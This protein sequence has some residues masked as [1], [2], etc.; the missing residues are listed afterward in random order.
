MASI[1]LYN[2]NEVGSDSTFT[3][4]TADE[5][6]A[7]FLY[8][9]DL[10]TKLSSSGSANGV[11]E[12]FQIVFP[13]SKTI[14]TV[15][16]FGHNIED[17][18]IK[19]LDGSLVEQDF[20]SPIAFSSNTTTDD[21]FSVTDQEC[22]GIV[23]NCTNTQDTGEK[24][25]AQLRAIFEFDELDSPVR[26]LPINDVVSD[27]KT[28][29]DGG[30]DKI[31]N[32]I[33]FTAQITFDKLVDADVL[34]LSDLSERGTPFYIYLSPLSTDKTK[35]FFRVQDMYL[36]N[37]IND[38]SPNLPDGLVDDVGWTANIRVKEV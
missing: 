7:A 8:D 18:N 3:F 32:G 17:G 9:N 26:I 6:N 34:T 29:F 27:T 22:L 28:K 2:Q 5:D 24:K 1:K 36:V 15:A 4:T 33:K 21:V 13:S 23:V 37:M 20:T 11:N 14:D 19:Y 10:N 16:I 31:I 25:I 35:K 30:V 12:K 38:F